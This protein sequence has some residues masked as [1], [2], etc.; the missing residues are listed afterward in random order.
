MS[1][2]EIKQDIL[3]SCFFLAVFLSVWIV[4]SAIL[5]SCCGRENRALIETALILESIA[6]SWIAFSLIYF[7]L[8]P[9]LGKF[10]F[11]K[12][13]SV[14][15]PSILIV[16]EVVG[17]SSSFWTHHLEFKEVTLIFDGKTEA[18]FV[19]A[20]VLE[21]GILGRP[22]LKKGRFLLEADHE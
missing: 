12:E 5:F 8:I 2:R 13:T 1:K 3:L 16:Q 21:K 6:F 7:I 4:L 10:A 19:E 20:R 14:Y 15:P 22:L 18:L 17:V 9:S 11:L